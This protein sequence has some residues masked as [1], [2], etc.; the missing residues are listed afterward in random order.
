MPSFIVAVQFVLLTLF[1][2]LT[3]SFQ[4]AVRLASEGGAVMM[5]PKSCPYYDS[6]Q[7]S[8]E[9]LLGALF[10]SSSCDCDNSAFIRFFEKSKKVHAV[11]SMS[12]CKK[13][14]DEDLQCKSY[15]IEIEESNGGAKLNCIHSGFNCGRYRAGELVDATT[16]TLNHK[17]ISIVHSTDNSVRLPNVPTPRGVDYQDVR[18]HCGPRCPEKHS[19]L[20]SS[21]SPGTNSEARKSVTNWQECLKFCTSRLSDD[22]CQFWSY[23]PDNDETEARFGKPLRG[24]CLTYAGAIGY[25]LVQEHAVSGTRFAS[26]RDCNAICSMRNWSEWSTCSKPCGG[27]KRTR[28]RDVIETATSDA[29]WDTYVQHNTPLEGDGACGVPSEPEDCNMAPCPIFCEFGEWTSEWGAWVNDAKS[30]TVSCGGGFASRRRDVKTFPEHGAPKC[31]LEDQYEQKE[32]NPQA[33]PGCFTTDWTEWTSCDATCEIGHRKRTRA[34]KEPFV[35]GCT[36]LE[37]TGQCKNVDSS[38]NI[39]D[40]PRDC[41]VEPDW[42]SWSPCNAQ[43]NTGRVIRNRKIIS[44]HTGAGRSCGTLGED[45][46]YTYD[47][48]VPC[49]AHACPIDCVLSEWSEWSD[50]SATCGSGYRLKTRQI[51]TPPTGAGKQCQD[52]YIEETCSQPPCAREADSCF[53]PAMK[54]EGNSIDIV[55]A[56][57]VNN[58]QISCSKTIDTTNPCVG[59]SYDNINQD[60][61]MYSTLVAENRTLKFFESGPP[62]CTSDKEL[63]PSGGLPDVD[64]EEGMEAAGGGGANW[65]VILGASG[66]VLGLLLLGAGAYLFM[67]KKDNAQ[68][69]ELE[70]DYTAADGDMVYVRTKDF[71]DDN[72]GA[73]TVEGRG[74]DLDE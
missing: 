3:P 37:Q 57:D 19:I 35:A 32:C 46:D 24:M 70:Y 47:Q 74:G 1:Q 50:C 40:C 39:V 67:R 17:K 43:C 63:D 21:A 25:R 55:E 29:W 69:D 61:Y 49:N 58:C 54:Y 7:V 62:R 20:I 6:H 10:K 5:D 53:E 18:A 68:E 2:C 14:C 72:S 22:S 65:G 4:W 31:L 30:C 36:E 33:C 27:G 42:L 26:Q 56:E 45:Y 48:I 38:G 13:A 15:S 60:C 23:L 52:F 12:Q 34:P 9:P 64:I 59:F 51:V 16:S 66:G 71:A 44:W 11:T 41:V 73:G 28:Q 8:C